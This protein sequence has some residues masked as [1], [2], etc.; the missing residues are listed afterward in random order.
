MKMEFVKTFQHWT[1]GI[2]TT[3]ACVAVLGIPVTAQ[4]VESSSP[5]AL[6]QQRTV[7]GKVIDETGEPMIG[8]TVKVEG[9]VGGAITD[10]DGN[11]TV[12]A[13]SGANL[14][15]SYTGYK[16][17]TVRAD[18]QQLN[19]SM[20]PDVSGL[21]EVVVIG[22]GTVTKRDLTGSVAQVKSDVILQ[23]PTS[24]VAASLQGRIT[25]L[26]ISG[27]Q[28]R[29][30][31]NRSIS[32]SNDPLVIIDGVQGGSMSDLNPDDI[33]TIDVL[34]DASSTA[35]YGSQGAN[36]VIII[37]TKKAAAGKLSVSY[38]G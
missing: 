21:D 11:F 4:A 34:K 19:V 16:S 8:V 17:Q 36:G 37:T 29:I 23:T 20:E 10:L 28:M 26:D 32:G 12:A 24:D 14:V 9:A 5:Q 2:M 25:G 3:L 22:F 7:K 27:G 33:E 35:I 31:G 1:R 38:N 6:Q 13:P 18:R 15:F 30:R